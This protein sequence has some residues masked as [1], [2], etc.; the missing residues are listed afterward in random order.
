MP[1]GFDTRVLASIPEAAADE[2]SLDLLHLLR[3]ALAC[4]TLLML[5]SFTVRF[6]AFQQS[7]TSELAYIEQAVHIAW[8]P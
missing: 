5:I 3:R 6:V 1:L 8:T 4:A 2:D 7:S